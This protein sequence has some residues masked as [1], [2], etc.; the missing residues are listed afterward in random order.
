MITDWHPCDD[1]P[2][3]VA[4]LVDG[5]K[6]DPIA[7]QKAGETVYRDALYVQIGPVGSHDYHANELKPANAHLY[8]HRISAAWAEYQGQQP[9]PGGT[10]IDELPGLDADNAVKLKLAGLKTIDQLAKAD[11]SVLQRLHGPA[12]RL[13]REAKEFLAGRDREAKGGQGKAKTAE[14]PAT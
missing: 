5:K 7:S 2:Q 10:P 9:D 3:A 6:A 11:E 12:Q 1:D 8:M 13:Q 4:R 14:Q